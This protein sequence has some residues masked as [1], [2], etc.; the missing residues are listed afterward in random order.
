MQRNCLY[1]NYSSEDKRTEKVNAFY[2]RRIYWVHQE[3][4][5]NKTP[6]KKISKCVFFIRKSFT[7]SHMLSHD[8]IH[9]NNNYNTQHISNSIC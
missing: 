7:Y 1:V 3:K 8:I 2:V 6:S 9:G 5:R 4:R